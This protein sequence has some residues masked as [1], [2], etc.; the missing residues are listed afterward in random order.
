MQ[1]KRGEGRDL[2]AKRKYNREAKAAK[3][4]LRKASP[5]LTAAHQEDTARWRATK[6]AKLEADPAL[7]AVHQED[8]TQSKREP[9]KEYMVRWNATKRA[10]LEADPELMAAHKAQQARHEATRKEKH[11]A[12]PELM[13]ARKAS[14]H[15]RGVQQSDKV[16]Q[17]AMQRATHAA[18]GLD[19]V[20]RDP[21]IIEGAA[22]LISQLH[23]VQAQATRQGKVAVFQCF[24]AAPAS[25][26][27]EK[28]PEALR[29]YMSKDVRRGL[30]APPPKGIAP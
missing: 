26:Y 18:P 7:T 27:D 1:A 15:E 17:R 14:Q 25:M 23:V 16:M 8:T 2:D 5:A 11:E 28:H 20:P 22:S 4:V 19:D 30:P 29:P 12:D 9:K 6:R 21:Q 13:A 10:N 3:A 24:Y